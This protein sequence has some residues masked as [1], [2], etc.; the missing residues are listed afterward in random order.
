MFKKEECIMKLHV[1][2][3]T[4]DLDHAITCAQQIK[5]YVDAFEVSTLLLYL[6]GITALKRFCDT[7]SD[8]PIL[9]D[10]KI[11][12][13]GKDTVTQLAPTGI[14]WISV[15]AGTSKNIIHATTTTAHQNGIQVMMNL[16]DASSIGQSALEAKNLG[17]DALLFHQPYQEEETLKLFDAWDMLHGNTSLPIFVSGHI[18]QETAQEIANLNPSGIVVSKHITEADAPVKAAAYFQSLKSA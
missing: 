7:F 14:E 2:F 6:H 18:T 12:D 9:A 8:I 10:T 15:L 5:P 1:S 3:E 13:R 17:A 4:P 16:L 11:L